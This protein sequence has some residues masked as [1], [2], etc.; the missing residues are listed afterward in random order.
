MVQEIESI[1]VTFRSY[2]V[3][4]WDSRNF[5]EAYWRPAAA[6]ESEVGIDKP[7]GGMIFPEALGRP[8]SF[9][10]KGFLRQKFNTNEW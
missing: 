5:G 4:P 3:Y 2:G 9:L 7:L 10:K 1:N 8:F 6:Q